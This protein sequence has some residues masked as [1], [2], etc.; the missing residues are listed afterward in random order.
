LAEDLKRDFYSSV[1]KG[2]GQ[3]WV[4]SDEQ[5]TALDMGSSYARLK[6]FDWS[7]RL[8]MSSNK[9]SGLRQPLLQLKLDRQLPNGGLDENL[10]E[11]DELELDKLIEKLKEAKAA[12]KN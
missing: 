9:V 2:R 1:R 12:L 7:L 5:S 3:S 8:V 4:M 6:D 11:M 10:I